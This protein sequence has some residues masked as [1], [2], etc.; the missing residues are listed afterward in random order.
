[1]EEQNSSRNLDQSL[2][3][4]IWSHKWAGEIRSIIWILIAVFAFKS[5]F[6]ANYTVPTGSMKPAI[7]PGDKLLVNKMAYTLRIPFTDIVL[8]EVSKPKRG[9]VI[10]FDN[11]RDTSINYVKRLIG[12]PGDRLTVQDGIITLN[13]E[14]LK[15]DVSIDMRQKIMQ[16]GGRYQETLENKTYTVRRTRPTLRRNRYNIVVP[17]GH[18]FAMG[19]NRDQSDDSRSWGFVP[20]KLL[21]GRAFMIYFSLEWRDD[22]MLPRLRSERIGMKLDE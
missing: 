3:Q 14:R 21:K 17:E 19:D 9:D 7:E 1:M 2:W 13:G 10:V 11:P 18:Y 5:V 16:E 12:L 22:T 20:Q 6:I 15:I 4:K 8:Y